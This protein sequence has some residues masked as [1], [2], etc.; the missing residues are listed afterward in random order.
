MLVGFL[1]VGLRRLFRTDPLP[2]APALIP[3]RVRRNRRRS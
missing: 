2:V 1:V 3:V